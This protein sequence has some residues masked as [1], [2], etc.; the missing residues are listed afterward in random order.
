VI[1]YGTGRQQVQAVAR[2]ESVTLQHV[3][4]PL[5]E[6]HTTSDHRVSTGQN[7]SEAA[8]FRACLP[9][10]GL[11][12]GGWSISSSMIAAISAG[13]IFFTRYEWALSG[14]SRQTLLPS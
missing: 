8:T 5:A 7:Q 9:F 14:D 3:E 1:H 4:I 13:G 6:R 10:Y 11:A 2:E 12:S